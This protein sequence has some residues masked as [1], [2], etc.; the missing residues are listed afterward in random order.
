MILFGQ[1]PTMLQRTEMVDSFNIVSPSVIRRILSLKVLWYTAK[2]TDKLID[3]NIRQYD[4]ETVDASRVM[5]DYEKTNLWHINPTTDKVHPA[6]FPSELASRIVRFYSFKG[7][8]V[9]DPFG[10]SGTVGHI[11]LTHERYFLLCEKELEYVER[12]NQVLNVNLFAHAKPRVL[13]LIELK[14]ELAER[15]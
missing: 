12:A 10:G 3:W 6:V 1:N 9:F 5:G 2:K 11:A 4:D 14:S 15:N 13:S 7:D 8:L